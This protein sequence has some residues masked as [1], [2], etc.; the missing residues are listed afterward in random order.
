MMLK[1]IA[2]VALGA[3]GAGVAPAFA[4]FGDA[5]GGATALGGLWLVMAG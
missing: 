5:G 1:R 2:V 3:L 4:H